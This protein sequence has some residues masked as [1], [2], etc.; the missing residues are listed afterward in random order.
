M[1]FTRPT[2]GALIDY[3]FDLEAY[4]LCRQHGRPCSLG[5]EGYLGLLLFLS[6][7]HNAIQASVSAFWDHSIS[8]QPCDKYDAEKDGLEAT[9][10]SNC[11]G[12]VP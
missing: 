8:L 9:V 4:A 2:F 5:P 6:G 1:G 3:L 12:Q 11:S 10:S 7:K